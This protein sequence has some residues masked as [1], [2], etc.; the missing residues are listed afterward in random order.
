MEQKLI[1]IQHLKLVISLGDLVERRLINELKL[2]HFQDENKLLI[3]EKENSAISSLISLLTTV[4]I[5]YLQD[6]LRSVL[7]KQWELLD[8]VH[9]KTLNEIER[10]RYA[11]LAQ[12]LNIDRIK[13]KNIINERCGSLLELKEYGPR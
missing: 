4:D 11:L 7:K 13:C 1:S 2:H 8:Q 5:A 6:G 12:S 9:D 10:G 3:L